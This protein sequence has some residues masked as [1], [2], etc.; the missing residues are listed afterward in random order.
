MSTDAS[1]L[2]QARFVPGMSNAEYHSLKQFVSSSMLRKLLKSPAHYKAALETPSESTK[3]MIFGSAAHAFQLEAAIFDKEYAV[4]P[5]SIDART[6]AGKEALAAF[7]E[8]NQGRTIITSDEMTIIREMAEAMQSHSQASQL[9]SVGKK[10]LSC[11]FTTNEIGINCKFRPDVLPGGCVIVDYKTTEDA[12]PAEF[13]KTCANYGYDIQAAFYCYGMEIL[14][15]QEHRF[16]FVA[17]EKKAPYEVAV[18][19]ASEEF[20]LAGRTKMRRLLDLLHECQTTDTWPG[21]P[22]EIQIIN[23]PGWAKAA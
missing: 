14:T 16:I 2:L 23:L 5:A 10:E 20:M 1:K 8:A 6:K 7:E 13:A 3:A 9:I 21:Y 12:S 19:E 11:F 4:R 18:Y 22:D 17:Q 15:G